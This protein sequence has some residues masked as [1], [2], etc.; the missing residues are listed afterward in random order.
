M[1]IG[2]L[3]AAIPKATKGTGSN[4]YKK[5]EIDNNVEFSKPKSEVLAENGLQ[6]KQ[7]ERFERIAKY[8]EAVEKAKEEARQELS[9]I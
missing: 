7:A 8:P 3:T 9:G 2:K 5:A 6:Q 1:Q 4:Q